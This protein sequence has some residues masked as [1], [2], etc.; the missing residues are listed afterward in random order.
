MVLLSLIIVY[1]CILSVLG[2][3][4]GGGRRL[5]CNL[6]EKKKK[7][8][9]KI[10]IFLSRVWSVGRSVR[11]CAAAPGRIHRDFAAKRLAVDNRTHPLVKMI[12]QIGDDGAVVPMLKIEKHWTNCIELFDCTRRTYLVHPTTD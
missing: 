3:T 6:A 4:E 5:R 7:K 8:K 12:G 2:A 11:P 10:G 9:K 1:G